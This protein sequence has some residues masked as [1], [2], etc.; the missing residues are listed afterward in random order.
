[1][2]L[3]E[4]RKKYKDGTITEEE[5]KLLRELEEWEW[6]LKQTELEMLREKLR[7]GQSLTQEEK[8]RLKLLE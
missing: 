2:L 3:E 5:M 8:N 6:E 1:M 7:K 4:L